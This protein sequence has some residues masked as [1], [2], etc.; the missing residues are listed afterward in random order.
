MLQYVHVLFGLWLALKCFMSPE[1][2]ANM[3]AVLDICSKNVFT[4]GVF[5]TNLHAVVFLLILV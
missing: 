1:A 5:A 3:N 2:T 4:S